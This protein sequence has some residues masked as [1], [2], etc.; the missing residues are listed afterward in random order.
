MKLS[1]RSILGLG[2]VTLE[3]YRDI[4]AAGSL[5]NLLRAE[6]LRRVEPSACAFF[7]QPNGVSSRYWLSCKTARR[8]GS[9]ACASQERLFLSEFWERGVVLA[10]MKTTSLDVVTQGLLA[11]YVDMTSTSAFE[12]AVADVEICPHAASY[13]AGA[14]NYVDYRWSELLDR[15][16]DQSAIPGLAELV[17]AAAKRVELR[18]LLPFTSHEWLSFSRCTGYPF[19]GDCPSIRPASVS[20]F[21]VL[22]AARKSLG[23]GDVGETLNIVVSNLPEEIGPAV[24]GRADDLG[25][26]PA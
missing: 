16:N 1:A 7:H 24:H 4:A 26:L 9:I 5:E 17:R 6:L 3:F 12:R 25:R 10:R 14:S 21:Q 8:H 15:S 23:A 20:T 13:Q 19:S 11:W 2:D 22:G 18:S